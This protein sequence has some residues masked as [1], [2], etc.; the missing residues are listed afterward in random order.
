ML[1]NTSYRFNV[2]E[3]NT[4]SPLAPTYGPFHPA[5]TTTATSTIIHTTA[6]IHGEDEKFSSVGRES[7]HLTA[8]LE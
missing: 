1:I 5:F 6:D 4:L 8:K 3:K 2:D 7:H